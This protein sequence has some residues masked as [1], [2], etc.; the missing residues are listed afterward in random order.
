MSSIQ[1]ALLSQ[2]LPLS[3]SAASSPFAAKDKKSLP[4]PSQ[5]PEKVAKDFEGVFTSMMLK[6]MRKTLEPGSLFG[7]DSSD[8]YGGLFDQFLGQHMADS[9]G[10]GLA[11]MIQE[12]LVKAKSEIE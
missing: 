5:S 6:E 11:R 12:S 1:T 8:I 3:E 7:E 9:G 10:I 2:P 4:M